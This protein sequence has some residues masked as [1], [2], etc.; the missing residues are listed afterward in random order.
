MT[1]PPARHILHL[2]YQGLTRDD[3]RY[4]LLLE[5]AATISA[6]I[7]ALPPDAAALDLTGAVRYFGATPQEVADMVRLRTL[8]LAGVS[9]TAGLGP[10]RMLAAIAAGTADPGHLLVVPDEDHTI[11]RFLHPHPVAVL[12]GIGPAT[13][14]TLA[15]YGLDTVGDL[16]RTPLPTLQ[17][18][19]GAS[20][21]LQ[22]H[23]RAHA[24][25]PRPVTPKAPPRT[26]TRSVRFGHDT[27]DPGDH[28]RAVLALAHDL[29]AQLRDT[30]SVAHT[31]SLTVRFA[32]RS[33]TS[34]SRT[35]PEATDHT[36]ALTSAASTVLHT[37]ALQRARVRA[38]TMTIELGD[39]AAAA[40]QLNFDP[41]D[42]RQRRLEEATDR[43]RRRFGPTTIGPALLYR[44][45]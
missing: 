23:H 7:Q 16:A 11:V 8:A 33:S 35:L 1:T 3:V 42:E 38:I 25:D 32:D 4:P 31:M 13:A 28:H 39:P 40:H 10:S 26:I 24:Y 12:P 34:R 21:G 30:K 18:I 15:R 36:R 9:T 5:I 44:A 37:L 19:L 17:R 6:R 20:A 2:H 29:G 14:R 43:A 45:A 27:L 41:T 22:A